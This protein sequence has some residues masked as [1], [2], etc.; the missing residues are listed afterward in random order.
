MSKMKVSP[1]TLLEIL[2]E[3]L[4]RLLQGMAWVARHDRPFEIEVPDHLKIVVGPK[5]SRG[6]A[7]QLPP[8]DGRA[9][10]APTPDDQATVEVLWL[11]LDGM[12]AKA[13]GRKPPKKRKAR[14]G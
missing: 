10:A 12:D 6:C 14:K 9:C 1:I 2:A 13:T 5:D 3:L 7:S 8:K 11:V 4:N